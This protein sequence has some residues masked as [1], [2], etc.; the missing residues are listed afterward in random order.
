MTPLVAAWSNP[1]VWTIA[2]ITT[3]ARSGHATSSHPEVVPET[4]LK[5]NRNHAT[6][7]KR[8]HPEFQS[9]SPTA[10]YG[11]PTLRPAG[12]HLLGQVC[13]GGG[14]H[15]IMKLSAS[16]A[17]IPTIRIMVCQ[18][19]TSQTNLTC[20][21]CQLKEQGGRANLVPLSNSAHTLA[22]LQELT[23]ASRTFRSLDKV[24]IY[25]ALS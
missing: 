9:P 1:E 18:W 8:L 6:Q 5:E 23:T 24:T 10:Q 21:S 12:Y 14:G 2:G 3:L 22:S 11:K 20:V 16:K 13:L 7:P 15:E 17:V 25:I 4:D 19:L